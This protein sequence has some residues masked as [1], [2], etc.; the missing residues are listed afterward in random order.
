MELIIK[1]TAEWEVYGEGLDAEYFLNI[2]Q[3]AANIYYASARGLWRVSVIRRGTQSPILQDIAA[4]P[5]D[6]QAAAEQAIRD[7]VEGR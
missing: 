7:A 4:T 6:A 5:A 2:A 1:H 3:F